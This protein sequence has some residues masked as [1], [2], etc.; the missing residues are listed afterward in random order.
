MAG[1]SASARGA[2]PT[3]RLPPVS[4]PGS[5]RAPAGLSVSRTLCRDPAVAAG[6]K[7]ANHPNSVALFANIF[8]GDS[9]EMLFIDV[10]GSLRWLRHTL[11]QPVGWEVVDLGVRAHEVV[12]VTH[13]TGLVFALVIVG[14]STI[15]AYVLEDRPDGS[16]GPTWSEARF[17]SPTLVRA[18]RLSIQY[19]PQRPPNAYAFAFDGGRGAPTAVT[20][21]ESEIPVEGAS[22]RTEAYW[23]VRFRTPVDD[24]L[25]DA[26]R[27]LVCAMD[28]PRDDP[29]ELLIWSLGSDGLL[30]ETRIESTGG[31][32]NAALA[33]G[34][35][36]LAGLFSTPRGVGCVALKKGSPTVRPSIVVRSRAGGE[37]R[38]AEPQVLDRYLDQARVWQD[39]RGMTHVFGLADGGLHVVSQVGLVAAKPT[40]ALLPVWDSTPRRSPVRVA[41][42]RPVV[43]GVSGFAL[44][45]RPAA[46]AS[47][48]VRHD[49]GT[50][51]TVDRCAIYTQDVDVS[52]S[53]PCTV[54]RP[55]AREPH[56]VS[57]Y[58]T[59]L[60]LVD[61]C[62]RP[63]ADR[64]VDLTSDQPI[65]VEVLGSFHRTSPGR[66]ARLA[67]D[68]RGTIEL[69]ALARGPTAMSVDL[70]VGGAEGNT[71]K[72]TIRG[73]PH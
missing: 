47:E 17:D 32:E 21:I 48:H 28:G 71:I 6:I 57:R 42:V 18:R 68:S 24:G 67:T 10:A 12:A 40:R 19:V 73:T 52:S 38:T 63:L 13:P 69:Q 65:E 72:V 14:R 61:A 3:R 39:D 4:G 45:P 23:R 62:G 49:A 59:L 53:P 33:T 31:R 20:V 43:A 54:R 35:D 22:P 37:D 27:Q 16:S 50:A 41:I 70:H 26:D 8:A 44:D 25:G 9:E 11:S 34:V 56:P 64:A 58:K 36:A 60:T 7:I 66:P 5:D 55:S 51:S 46:H 1:R 2:E 29:D 15:R 30:H